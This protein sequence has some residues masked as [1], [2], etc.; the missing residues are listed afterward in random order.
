MSVLALPAHLGSALMRWSF[1]MV[2]GG[3][4]GLAVPFHSAPGVE[5]FHT[6]AEF[7]VNGSGMAP[8]FAGNALAL[9]MFFSREDNLRR[10]KIVTAA[11]KCFTLRDADTEDTQ[12]QI[13][14][15][16]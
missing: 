14:C 6:K 8:D 12:A 11:K 1:G 3:L 9:A 13:I 16:L 4:L 7:H 5:E 2:L 10:Q 15:R